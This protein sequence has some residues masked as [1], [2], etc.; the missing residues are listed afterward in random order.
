MS[1]LY[2]SGTSLKSIYISELDV[3]LADK[4]GV[5][6]I[7]YTW[8]NEPRNETKSK[9]IKVRLVYFAQKKFSTQHPQVRHLLQIWRE[10]RGSDADVAEMFAA[11][12]NVGSSTTA[13]RQEI[14]KVSQNSGNY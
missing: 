14:G 6:D 13:I 11:L 2:S 5:G 10:S 4:L 7:Y 1:F 8:Q 9:M 3:V 12:E